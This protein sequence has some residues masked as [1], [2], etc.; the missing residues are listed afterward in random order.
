MRR[1]DF[2]KVIAGSAIAWPLAARAQQSDRTRRIG[3]L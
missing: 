2:V 1:R 3:W